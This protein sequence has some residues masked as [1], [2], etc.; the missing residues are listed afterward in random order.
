LPLRMVWTLIRL[1]PYWRNQ[2]PV[3]HLLEVMCFIT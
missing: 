1:N 2:W 3:G